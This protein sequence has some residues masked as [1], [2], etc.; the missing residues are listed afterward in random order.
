MTYRSRPTAPNPFGDIEPP[1]EG[2]LDAVLARGR[3]DQAAGLA[4]VIEYRGPVIG[5]RQYRPVVTCA[6][7]ARIHLARETTQSYFDSKAAKMRST[8]RWE[9]TAEGQRAISDAASADPLTFDLA[10]YAVNR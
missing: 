7:L 4:P 3:A 2:E 10:E 9:I 1:T 8:T 5:W 6:D